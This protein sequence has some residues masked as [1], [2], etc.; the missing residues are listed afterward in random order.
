MEDSTITKLKLIAYHLKGNWSLNTILSK[1]RDYY[2]QNK[3][4]LFI[5]I[6][7][8]YGKDLPQWSLLIKNVS[9]YSK[10]QT[11]AKIGCSLD[12]PTQSIV[13][14]L[15]GRLL[16]L[17]DDAYKTIEANRET[18]GNSKDLAEQRHYV[19]T[20][21]DKAIRINHDT[22]CNVNHYSLVDADDR[23]L[24]LLNQSHSKVDQFHLDLY[25]LTSEQVIKIMDIL[26]GTK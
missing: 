11:I 13:N 12:K 23:K 8:S 4:G 22:Q 6:S 2:L 17:S 26:G 18:K 10:F 16:T 25:Y 19:M 20:A 9:Y 15:K 24:G 5:N 7:Y 14:D 21:L 1:N 3:Q